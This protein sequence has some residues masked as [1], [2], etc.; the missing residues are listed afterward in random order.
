[1]ARDDFRPADKYLGAKHIHESNIKDGMNKTAVF[2]QVGRRNNKSIMVY[3]K[4]NVVSMTNTPHLTDRNA[5]TP[6]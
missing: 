3:G 4:Q 2:L 6:R 1:M 5:L